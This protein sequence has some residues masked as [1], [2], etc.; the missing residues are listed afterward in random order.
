MNLEIPA[1]IIPDPIKELEEKRQQKLKEFETIN[2][3]EQ[4][5][6]ELLK[7]L[8]ERKLVVLAEGR[9]IRWEI[10]E[11][12]KKKELEK[13]EK[14][15]LEKLRAEALELEA[16]FKKLQELLDDLPAFAMA[17]QYQLEDLTVTLKAYLDGKH[18]VIN[19]NDM[20]LGKTF[21]A[22]LFI[23]CVK[24][25][26]PDATILWLTKKSLL[27][28]TPNEIRRWLPGQMVLTSALVNTAQERRNLLGMF[29]LGADFLVANY[30]FVRTTPEIQEMEW[31]LVIV[32]EAHKLKGGANLSGPTDVW[33][34]VKKLCV[35]TKFPIFLTGTPTPNR[36]AEMWAYLN[37][38]DEEKFPSLRQFE[39]SLGIYRNLQRSFGDV[40]KAS[41]ILARVLG[42]Q[43]IRRTRKEV[44]IQLPQ[45]QEETILLDM[46]PEQRQVYNQMRDFF[47]IWLDEQEGK[48]LTATAILAQLTR[49]RQISIWPHNIKFTIK[50]ENGDPMEHW[51]DCPYGIKIDE[52]ID[53][54]ENI[55]EQVVVF[56]NFNEPLYELDRR[57]LKMDI[58]AQALTGENSNEVG[59]YEK[60]F[61]DGQIDVLL[62]NSAVGEGLNLQK[63]PSKWSGGASNGIMLDRWWN[64]ARNYQCRD[65]IIRPGDPTAKGFF[66][67]MMCQSSVDNFILS[68]CDEKDAETGEITESQLIRPDWKQYLE[69]KI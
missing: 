53:T 28:S 3:R 62:M 60:L 32:D 64:N 21:E 9:K 22:V 12:E 51:L 56:S 26:H 16:T 4:E 14:E 10:E 38:F 6:K 41:S 44:G 65:R 2:K 49:L 59:K 50:S 19:A 47:F 54:I 40:E 61:Q 15:K 58:K 55:N 31:D 27:I 37:I 33:K 8:E 67:Y 23:Y 5:L 20:S 63:D 52:T 1:L 29:S 66:Y 30:E 57:L 11:L 35:N 43:M 39:T 17:R 69:D 36:T 7:D 68:L 45:I 24:K 13:R 48:A 42:E 46:Y 18:G 25:L 34:A